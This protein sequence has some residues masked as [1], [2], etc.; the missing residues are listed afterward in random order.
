MKIPLSW[1]KEYIPTELPPE[2]IAHMLTQ[3]GLE[4]DSITPA[5]QDDFVFEIA[6]TPNLAHCTGVRGIARELG[7]VMDKA[8]VLPSFSLMEQASDLIS[9]QVQVSVENIKDCPR[10][11]CRVIR[12]IKVAPSPSWLIDKLEMCGMRSVNN[13][14]DIT[15]LTMLELGQPLHAFDLDRLKN[16]SIV[17]RNARK[18]EKIVT[19]DGKE[20]FPTEETLLICDGEGPVALAGIMGAERAEV[21][22]GT[23]SILLESAYFEPRSIRRSAKHLDIHSEASYRFERGCDPLAVAYALDRAAS[24]ID[25]LAE[26]TLCLG[27]IDLQQDVFAPKTASCRL[28]RVN[29]LLGTHLA[30]SEIETIFRRLGFGI[31]EIKEESIDVTIPTYRHDVKEEIDLIEEVARLY[32]LDNIRKNEKATFRLGKLPH[33]PAYL[34][35]KK[36][37]NCLLGEGLQELLNCDLISPF[38]ADLIAPDCMPFRSQIKLLNPSSTE[39]SILRPS[40]LPGLLTTLKYNVDHDSHSLTGFEVGRIHFK[41]KEDYVERAMAS[42]ILMGKR[43]EKYWGDKP[44]DIDFFDLKGIIENL[45]EALK[46]EN[47]TFLPSHF[48]NFHPSRQAVVIKDDM[49]LGIIGEVHP[50]TLKRVGL[51][52]AVFFAELNLEDLAQVCRAEIKMKPLPLY[53]A[54]TRDW[55]ITLDEKCL[56]ADVLALIRKESSSLLESV[57]LHDLYRSEKL[58]PTLKNATFRFIYRDLDKTVSIQAVDHEHTRIIQHVLNFLKEPT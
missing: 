17:V 51:T 11:A 19:L 52:S 27:V 39:Q 3:I 48:Q 42:V 20:H 28:A 10:Y 24:W 31:I 13:I 4:V 15:N 45:L 41:A 50:R 46:I 58:G 57:S 33:S 5:G 23:I 38:Q 56:I 37:R 34:F 6:L 8:L 25:Q 36:V 1:L 2:K 32:G 43:F 49:E 29:S 30:M 40:L 35:E 16:H 9:D 54:S 47:Y 12:N 21:H 18:G 53:P 44:G 22:E 55:T 26:G 14:V 7:A